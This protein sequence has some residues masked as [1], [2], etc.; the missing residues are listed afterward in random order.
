MDVNEG[1]L[2]LV[3]AWKHRFAS[4]CQSHVQDQAFGARPISY[5]RIQELD[6]SV[7]EFYIPPSLQVPGFMGVTGGDALE[8]PT[9]ELTMQRYIAFA[10]KEI[11]KLTVL[12]R[13]CCKCFLADLFTQQY[14]TCTAD[15][16][17]EP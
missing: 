3:A 5:K 7:R 16:L 13:A 1:I 12:T 14:S 2:D 15:S 17:L 6:K 11:S 10:I 9:V 4:E 8:R